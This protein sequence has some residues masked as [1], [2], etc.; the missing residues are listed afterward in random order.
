MNFDKNIKTVIH[1]I[2][3]ITI[4]AILFGCESIPD[5][6]DGIKEPTAED[7]DIKWYKI[8]YDE[9]GNESGEQ[10]TGVVEYFTYFYIKIKINNYTAGS[11]AKIRMYENETIISDELKKPKDGLIVIKTY[12]TRTVSKLKK[13]K[14]INEDAYRITVELENGVTKESGVVAMDFALEVNYLVSK[15]YITGNDLYTLTST[16]GA[17]K[18][19]LNTLENGIQFTDH[20]ILKFTN[21]MPAKNYSLYYKSEEETE[22]VY[23]WENIP[24]YSL[25]QTAEE[26]PSNN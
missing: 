13:L 15:D 24:F 19:T 6:N 14:E 11:A 8:L 23:M 18:K 16:D 4:A 20:T 26:N 21:L 25:F 2:A 3:M 17:Y 7:I 1:I 9:N 12:L 10:E 22:G 5:K